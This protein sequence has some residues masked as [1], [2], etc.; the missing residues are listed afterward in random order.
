[1]PSFTKIHRKQCNKVDNYYIN[2]FVE[3]DAA[4][5]MVGRMGGRE[6]HIR[7]A[8]THLNQDINTISS[9]F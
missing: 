9:L 6:G 8:F 3:I 5:I 2:M 4:S 7:E 1:M